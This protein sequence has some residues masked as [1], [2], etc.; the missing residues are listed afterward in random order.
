MGLNSA[1]SV[2]DLVG[3]GVYLTLV[4][5]IACSYIVERKFVHNSKTTLQRIT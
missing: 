5:I 1:L 4:L 2:T 3:L